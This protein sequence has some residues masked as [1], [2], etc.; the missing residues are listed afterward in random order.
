MDESGDICRKSA[1]QIGKAIILG[2]QHSVKQ[3][4]RN[5]KATFRCRSSEGT[6]KLL[7][8]SSN[9]LSLR[10]VILWS[11]YDRGMDQNGSPHLQGYGIL[12]CKLPS[13]EKYCLRKLQSIEKTA[14]MWY[15][16]SSRVYQ[17]RHECPSR[18]YLP[19][20]QEEPETLS[21]MLDYASKY[22]DPS[23]SELRARMPP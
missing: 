11:P 15:D 3:T 16:K 21:I 22:W 19:L 7:L 12:Q 23:V 4:I 2:C 1:D 17:L 9:F 8:R 6:V 13:Y 10:M 5:N 18:R 20:N 14:E